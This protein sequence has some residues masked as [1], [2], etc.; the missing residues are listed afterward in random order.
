MLLLEIDV[1]KTLQR[2]SIVYPIGTTVFPKMVS[3]LELFHEIRKEDLS[4][5]IIVA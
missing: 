5:T 1:A 2:K 3:S 4:K